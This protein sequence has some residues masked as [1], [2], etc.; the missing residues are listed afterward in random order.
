MQKKAFSLTEVLLVMGIIAV[1][2]AMGFS[3][4]KKGDA[5]LLSPACAS[6][7]FFSSYIE[8]GNLFKKIVKEIGEN[9]NLSKNNP[10]SEMLNTNLASISFGGNNN[11]IRYMIIC[12]IT[13]LKS[14]IF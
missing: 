12:I 14:I 9:E 6:F 13:W 11:A 4:S 2:T 8:R 10:S 1:V 5:V 7:D 3:I